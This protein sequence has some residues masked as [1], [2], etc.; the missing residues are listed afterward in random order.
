MSTGIIKYANAEKGFFFI[1]PDDGGP[2]VFGHVRNMG[3][4]RKPQKGD[5]VRY[6]TKEARRGGVEACNISIEP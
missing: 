5:R 6:G 3:E 1:I 4:H 2:D